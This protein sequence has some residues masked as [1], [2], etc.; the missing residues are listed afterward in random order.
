MRSKVFITLLSTLLLTL[1]ACSDEKPTKVQLPV[2]ESQ[3]EG[4]Y[5]G[6]L[7]T[8]GIHNKNGAASV[9]RDRSCREKQNEECN[10]THVEDVSNLL[11]GTRTMQVTPGEEISFSMP[12]NPGVPMELNGLKNIEI[13]LVQIH[14]G[15]QLV[16]EH[17]GESFNAP[18][19]PGR[20][21]YSAVVKWIGDIKGEASYAFA[22]IVK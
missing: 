11:S 4:T 21:N 5:T 8:L 15:E 2:E 7:P 16:V 3:D 22:I 12:T 13:D 9:R 18:Q 14:K 20:Y 17:N 6:N 1:T 10:I 19:E